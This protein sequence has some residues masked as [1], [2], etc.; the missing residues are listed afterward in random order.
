MYYF[1][2]FTFSPSF[3]GFYHVNIFMSE[4]FILNVSI[5]KALINVIIFNAVNFIHSL[6]DELNECT[7]ALCNPELMKARV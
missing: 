7:E 4:P 6:N 5:C 3:F 1:S 2:F